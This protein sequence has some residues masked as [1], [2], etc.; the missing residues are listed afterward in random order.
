ML[1]TIDKNLVTFIGA[2]P[3]DP[4]LVTRKGWQ[5]L[6]EADV[7]LFDALLDLDGFK[8]AAPCARWV[9]VGKRVGQIST[10]QSFISKSIVNLALR[11]YRIVRLKGGDPAVFGRMTE[12]MDACKAANLKYEIIPGVTAA[13]SCAAEL[14]ISLTQR[15]VSRSVTF[16]TPRTSKRNFSS[17]HW[18]SSALSSDTVV[19]YMA[20]IELP[21]IA[22]TL[23][24]RG[25]D[26]KTPVALVE[27]AS[28]RSKKYV[29]TLQRCTK[30]LQHGDGGP[31]TV[32]MGE[33][34][35]SAHEP[36]ELFET[37]VVIQK[38]RLK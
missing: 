31:I 22:Q 2:G 17:D 36:C 33:V 35:R 29:T 6:G 5:R 30:E 10:A 18:V 32:L 20:G 1:E 14:G 3:G 9:N 23:I 15:E 27:S 28:L 34:V 13:S 8:K 4:E 21:T 25:K 19:L 24:S 12:E 26:P 16:L 11:G 7:V 38:A 37:P